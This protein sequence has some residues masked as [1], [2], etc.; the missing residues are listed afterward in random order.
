MCRALKIFLALWLIL[1]FKNYGLSIT[2]ASPKKGKSSCTIELAFAQDWS[3]CSSSCP[4]QTFDQT[5]C[6]SS[7]PRRWFSCFPSESHG[8]EEPALEVSKV[9]EDSQRTDATLC[10]VWSTLAT[11]FR[12]ELHSGRFLEPIEVR[13]K[14]ISRAV[15]FSTVAPAE[16]STKCRSVEHRFTEHSTTSITQ[17]SRTRTWTTSRSSRNARPDTCG[18]FASTS[19]DSHQRRWKGLWKC[20]W[21]VWAGHFVASSCTCNLGCPDAILAFESSS[22][23]PGCDSGTSCWWRNGHVCANSCPTFGSRSSLAISSQRIASGT[24][25]V[26]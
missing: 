9:Y 8:Y 10:M 11:G 16:S 3:T 13:L 12:P 1:T 17:A 4:H 2:E 18:N 20:S 19:A 26:R 23:T 15:D 6:F 22:W 25:R 14:T 21:A 7:Q 24:G 5:T